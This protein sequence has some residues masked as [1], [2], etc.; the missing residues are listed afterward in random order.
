MARETIIT[1]DNCGCNK[2]TPLIGPTSKDWCV[3]TYPKQ[4][5]KMGPIARPTLS[6]GVTYNGE[7]VRFSSGGE[8]ALDLCSQECVGEMVTHIRKY[9]THNR[10][11]SIIE[12]CVNLPEANL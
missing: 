5:F 3:L 10:L 4:V 9:G 7:P 6:Y 2:D 1:C 12:K 8:I 11:Q